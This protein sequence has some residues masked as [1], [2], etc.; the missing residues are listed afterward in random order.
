MII[1][2]TLNALTK[3]GVNFRK[4][5]KVSFVGEPG[6]DEG[7]VQKEF[8]MIIIRQLFDPNY[9]MFTYNEKSRMYWFNGHTLESNIKFELVGIIL[10][11]A[12]YNT[13]IL[14]LHLPHACYKK[15][16]KM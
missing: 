14:G 5:L 7:G 3:P 2:D 6:V 1:E 4:P 16:L 13:N 9:T 8:F 15:L 11:L 10:G 12:I